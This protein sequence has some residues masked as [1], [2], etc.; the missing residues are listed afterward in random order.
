MKISASIYAYDKKL[1][2]QEIVKSLDVLY[3]D[4]FHIDCNDD[5]S[6]FNDIEQ[7]R[8]ISKTPI[9]LHIIT[10]HPAKYFDYIDKYKI[11]YVQFQ[12]E[13]LTEKHSV[14]PHLNNTKWGIGITNDTPYNVIDDFENVD[15]VLFMTTTPGV[16]GGVFNKNVFK[17]IRHFR[18]NYQSKSIFVDGGVN[19]EVAFVLRNIGVNRVVCGSYLAKNNSPARALIDLR[20]DIASSFQIKDFMMENIPVLNFNNASVNDVLLAI[21]KFSLGFV[22]F[23]NDDGKFI[24]ISSNADMRR[25]FIKNAD[26]FDKISTL[27]CINFKPFSLNENLT[28]KDMLN[29][30]AK[31]NFIVNF[32]PVV[33][34]DNI[35]VGA[36]TFFNLI[37]SEI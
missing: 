32:F 4:S 10:D 2:L 25:A 33:N 21:E 34:D 36:V 6:V 24:G 5:V 18:A 27:D 30:I 1:S 12:Y 13:N 3:I 26:N 20:K 19:A 28:I 31:Q 16:S 14:F 11:D 7:I 29:E 17:K 22:I 9:D 23:V 8:Q 35:P 15:F 37:R